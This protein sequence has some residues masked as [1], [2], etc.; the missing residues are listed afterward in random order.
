MHAFATPATPRLCAWG[1][2]GVAAVCGARPARVGG[3]RMTAAKT[4]DKKEVEEYFNGTGF[5]RWSR[6]YSDATDINS[7]QVS[8]RKGHAQTVETILGWLEEESPTSV[9]DAGCG[10]G[11]LSHPLALRG[12]TVHGVDISAAMVGEATAKGREQG[13]SATFAVGDVDALPGRADIVCCV[14]VLIHYPAADAMAMIGRLA[15]ACDRRLVLSFAPSTPLLDLL[16]KVGSFFP[17]AA[18]ATRA[19]LHKEEDVRAALE[20]NGFQ[21]RRSTLCKTNFYFSQVID[22]VRV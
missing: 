20:A 22:A 5:S 16:K 14:D 3:V 2:R 8:I 17:G 1:G 7:V 21:V 4:D 6:I 13:S 9:L 10:V 11:S 18:K 12:H 15:K 19:Y